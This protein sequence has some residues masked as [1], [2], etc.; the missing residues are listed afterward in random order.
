LELHHQSLLNLGAP[1][2]EILLV[3]QRSAP[4]IEQPRAFFFLAT[5]QKTKG[6][7]EWCQTLEQREPKVFDDPKLDTKFWVLR[8]KF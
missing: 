7:E 5:I 2:V 8:A 4:K 6:I 1:R 3:Q